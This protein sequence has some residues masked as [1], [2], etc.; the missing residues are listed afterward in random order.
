[1]QEHK[2]VYPS[3]RKPAKWL[4]YL[5]LFLSAVVIFSGVANRGGSQPVIQAIP[6]ATPIPLNEAFDE[7][8]ESRELTLEGGI[9]YGLQLGAFENEAA[10]QEL[11]EQYRHRGAAGYVWQEG[12]YHTLAAIY[13]SREDA[14]N[15]RQQLSANHSIESYLYEIPLQTLQLRMSGMKGQID[16]LQAA[17]VHANDLIAQLQRLSVQMDRQELTVEETVAS[18]DALNEQVSLV[19]LRLEQRFP[20]PRNAAVNGLIGVFSDYSLFLSALDQNQSAVEMGRNVKYQ[21]IQSLRLT[22]E[23]IDTLSNT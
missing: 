23:I 15:V 9:W 5:L 16:V 4:S 1:M 7:T 12:R 8:M 13:P 21:A 18:L 14:Q 11:A 20:S 2:R 6:T 3:Q 10:A 19:R 22:K 17:F